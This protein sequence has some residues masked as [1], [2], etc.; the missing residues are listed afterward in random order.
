MKGKTCS[1]IKNI[2]T[3]FEFLQRPDF[4]ILTKETFEQV[5]QS[6]LLS[7]CSWF[8]CSPCVTWLNVLQTKAAAAYQI[9]KL[10]DFLKG[11]I[12]AKKN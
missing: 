6:P 8:Y 10:V 5:D 4:P 9:R 3:R 11:K 2:L 12:E 7:S 1:L